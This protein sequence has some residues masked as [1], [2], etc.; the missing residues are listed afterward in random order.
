VTNADVWIAAAAL[1]GPT[2][3]ALFGVILFRYRQQVEQTDQRLITDGVQAFHT[4]LSGL[5]SAHLLNFQIAN[6]IIRYVKLYRRG[7][8]LT[9]GV[10]AVPEFLGVRRE[11]LP[12]TPLLPIQELIGDKVILD[13][14]MKALSDTTL[15]AKELD[16][17]IRQP[18]A[19]YYES[20]PPVSLDVDQ[21]AERLTRITEAWNS[22]V[23]PHFA[24][25]DRLNDLSREVARKRP[26]TV[27]GYFA[28]HRRPEVAAIREKMKAHL[29]DVDKIR[30]RVDRVL[31]SGGVEPPDELTSP[32]PHEHESQPAAE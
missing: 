9:P 25:L 6:Y 26:W 5:L 11:T 3:A 32:T 19:S 29:K 31:K 14:G 22:R 15:E 20:D 18:L 4:S 28:I 17:Q 10:L 30:E 12:I 1:V 23:E 8:P 2:L 21:A 16:F 7:E 24:L 13:W 27:G